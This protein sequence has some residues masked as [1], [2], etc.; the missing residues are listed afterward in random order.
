VKAGGRDMKRKINITMASL[1]EGVLLLQTNESFNGLLPLE[2]ILVDSE[3]FSFI[4]LMEDEIDYTYI[5]IP[6]NIWPSLRE[7]FEM[8]SSVILSFKEEQQ[9]LTNFHEELEYILNNIRGNSNY[10][11]EMVTKVEKLF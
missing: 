5:V 4:Y 7:S 10:G 11:E 2:Q 1:T 6:E 3:Q 9:E 8:K